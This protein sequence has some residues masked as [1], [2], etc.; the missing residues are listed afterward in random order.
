MPKSRSSF[1]LMKYVLILWP[2]PNS[3]LTS[4]IFFNARFIAAIYECC[5]IKNYPL[6]TEYFHLYLELISVL[7]FLLQ[8]LEA[9]PPPPERNSIF[10]D[11]E[12][13]KVRKSLISAC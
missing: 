4:C 5:T 1:Y 9:P 8:T 7:L 2:S 6:L 13:S 3:V 10:D 11:D 12:K